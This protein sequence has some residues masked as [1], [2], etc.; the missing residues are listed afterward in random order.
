MPVGG[1]YM[2]KDTK[3]DLKMVAGVII[4]LIEICEK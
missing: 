2:K 3:K 1:V 4:I